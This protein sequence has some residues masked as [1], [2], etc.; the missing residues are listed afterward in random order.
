MARFFRTRAG[1]DP[2]S[3]DPLAASDLS[4]RGRSWDPAVGGPF[5]PGRQWS[6]RPESRR[7]RLRLAFATSVAALVAV[8]AIVA[9]PASKTSTEPVATARAHRV[10]GSPDTSRDVNTAEEATASEGPRVLDVTT[11]GYD[12][13]G[14]DGNS[15]PPVGFPVYPLP[16]YVGAPQPTR[17]VAAVGDSLLFFVGFFEH[18]AL[19]PR[20][21]WAISVQAAPGSRW[22]DWLGD[23]QQVAQ[24]RP[25]V[26]LFEIGTNSARDEQG[27]GP[28]DS[29][30]F[31]YSLD[32]TD[33]IGC[34]LL[35]VPY[36]GP[37]AQPYARSGMARAAREYRAE[38]ARRRGIRIVAWDLVAG[39]HPEYFVDGVHQTDVGRHV[40]GQM[41]SR[42][43]DR[44]CAGP[45]GSDLT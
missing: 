38:A 28:D 36:A 7:R 44:A 26:V 10:K 45:R 13:N 31:N 3:V 43:L 19:W 23:M 42:A 6:A 16:A 8:V 35:V 30:M 33:H 25:D 1:G 15:A 4:H 32:R 27:W 21:G 12:P 37:T 5:E 20:P 29:W 2:L 18:W 39:G 9:I 17:R 22:K 41:I 11:D 24:M 34:R 14:F 40:Y